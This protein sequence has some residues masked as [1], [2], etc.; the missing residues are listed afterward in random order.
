MRYI[1]D[2]WNLDVII[3]LVEE[4][5]RWSKTLMSDVVLNFPNFE[6]GG[7]V[8]MYLPNYWNILTNR[9]HGSFSSRSTI[10]V[11]EILSYV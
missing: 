4:K 2:C 1:I 5:R 6:A 8:K 11:W 3:V 7:V 10:R 9:I